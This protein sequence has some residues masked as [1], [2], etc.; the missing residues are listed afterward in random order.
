MFLC[1]QCLLFTS[2]VKVGFSDLCLAPRYEAHTVRFHITHRT[3]ITLFPHFSSR[4]S[5]FFL[6]LGGNL[7]SVPCLWDH[8]GLI[9]M[10]E[11]SNWI[12]KSKPW[13]WS[14]QQTSFSLTAH[15]L[16]SSESIYPQLWHQSNN[17][18]QGGD[19]M[20]LRRNRNPRLFMHFIHYIDKDEIK[21][22]LHL[23]LTRWPI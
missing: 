17:P 16:N 18:H 23:F 4:V 7:P 15:T 5:I 14:L 21:T 8:V 22:Q 11:T 19:V 13:S 9:N 3:D 20:A 12:S 1:S 6:N 2:N 10:L